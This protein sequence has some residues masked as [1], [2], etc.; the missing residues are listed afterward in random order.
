MRVNYVGRQSFPPQKSRFAAMNKKIISIIAISFLFGHTA[1]AEKLTPEE[2]LMRM[3]TVMRKS[4][5]Q[6]IPKPA[7]TLSKELKDGDIYIF[8]TKSRDGYVML[9]GDDCVAPVMGYSTTGGFELENMPPQ[10]TWL[11]DEYG[12]QIEFARKRGL[13]YRKTSSELE[14]IE[15]M[16]QTLW[17]QGVPF[18]NLCPDDKN[19]K[20]YT[21]CVATAM[22]QVMNYWQYPAIGKGTHSFK[23]SSLNTTLSIDFAEQPMRWDVMTPIYKDGEYSQEAADAVAWLMKA[24]GYSVDMKYSSV[25]SGALTALVPKAMR[26]YFSYDPEI[27]FAERMVYSPA[28]WERLIHENLKNCGPVIYNGYTQLSGG[29]SFVCD[30]YDGEGRFH[31]NWGWSGLSDGYF[32][33]DIL[34]PD[35]QGIGG[36]TAGFNFK[37]NAILNIR[38][39]RGGEI[40]KTEPK[41]TQYGSLTATVTGARTVNIGL[42]KF[43]PLGWGNSNTDVANLCL[44]VLLEPQGSTP[45]EPQYVESLET[46]LIFAPGEYYVYEKPLTPKV[47]IPADLPQGTYRMSLV[48]KNNYSADEVWTPVVVPY[49]LNDYVTLVK[50]ENGL[51]IINASIPTFTISKAEL[52]GEVVYN[53][54]VTVRFTI[55]N[56]T[57]LHLTQGVSVV[58]TTPSGFRRFVGEGFNVTLRPG[59]SLTKEVASSLYVMG[60]PYDPEE[61]RDFVLALHNPVTNTYYGTYES[62]VMLSEPSGVSATEFVDSPIK[63]WYDKNGASLHIEGTDEETITSIYTADGQLFKSFKGRS[64]RMDGHGVYIIHTISPTGQH[65]TTKIVI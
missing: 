51:S 61:D 55:E 31:I 18:N 19:K 28:E 52:I 37:Q 58:L 13:S 33:L 35:S 50:D 1:V 41:L 62:T 56:N 48:T 38:P 14:P 26:D 63:V 32:M 45:G 60:G 65:S 53:H 43:N 39:N 64:C 20:S 15:P 6:S 42:E 24:C 4:P 44:G 12:R 9:S 23:P 2:A 10:M 40:T 27:T 11:I 21:G 59:E 25:S 47:R 7:L 57:D 29:H 22:A 46:E 3:G 36:S 34:D 8:E 30:G 5:G 54:P 16:I 17:D 49:G